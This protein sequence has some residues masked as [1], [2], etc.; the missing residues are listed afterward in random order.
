MVSPLTRSDPDEARK[1]GGNGRKAVVVKYN[2]E[3]ESKKLLAVYEDLLK[4]R[5]VRQ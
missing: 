2:W 5:Q 4:G 1:M 3:T